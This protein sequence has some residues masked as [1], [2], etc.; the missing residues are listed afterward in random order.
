VVAEVPQRVVLSVL[1][2]VVVAK[3]DMHVYPLRDTI[4]HDTES[5]DCICGPQVEAIPRED[6]S[7]GWMYTHQALGGRAVESG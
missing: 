3:G 1:E 4:E 2:A 6:G 7:F 5:D